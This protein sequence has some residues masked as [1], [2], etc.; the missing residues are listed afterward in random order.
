MVSWDTLAAHYSS[1]SEREYFNW[2]D[3]GHA[4]PSKL[5]DLFIERFPEIAAAGRGSDWLYA[6]WYLDMLHL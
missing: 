1:G 6:G 4:T 3:A 2:K 5:A